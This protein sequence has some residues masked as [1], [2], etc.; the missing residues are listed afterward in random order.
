MNAPA[1]SPVT[2]RRRPRNL[3]QGLVDSITERIRGGEI[4]PGDKL[5]TE[6]EIMREF[7]VSRTVVREALSRLQASGLVET[8]HGVGTYALEPSGGNDFRVDPAD[9]ATVRDVLVLLE[10]RICL[11]SEA[12]SLAAARR[13]QAQLHEMRRALDA[14]RSALDTSGDTVTPDFQFHLLVAQATGNRYF[15]DLMSHLGSA[16]IPRTRIN[17]AKFAHEDRAAYLERVN[18]EHE[19]IYGAILR[20]DAEAARAAMRTHLSNSRERLRRAQ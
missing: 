2:P 13:N 4:R 18:L 17:S 1:D 19:D 3:A 6:S 16:I 12:A 7:G 15:A 8:H 9:I 20:Q 5:P 10:L 14:F 11:E